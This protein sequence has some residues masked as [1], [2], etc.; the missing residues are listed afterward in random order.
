MT[1]IRSPVTAV[2]TAIIVLLLLVSMWPT[3]ARRLP[4]DEDHDRDMVG[5]LLHSLQ[6]GPVRPPG[7]GCSNI[8]KTGPPCIQNRNFAGR[9]VAPLN[10]YPGHVVQFGSAA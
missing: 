10:T 7:T 4:D 5:L 6:K 3:E 9:S 8:P 2:G 1:K